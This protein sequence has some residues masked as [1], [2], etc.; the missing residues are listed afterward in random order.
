M[1]KHSTLKYFNLKLRKIQVRELYRFR[2][3]QKT[4]GKIKVNTEL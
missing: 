2:D 1:Y 3:E 4:I